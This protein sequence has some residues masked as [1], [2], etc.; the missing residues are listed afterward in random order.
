MRNNNEHFL[1][2]KKTLA[3]YTVIKK[4]RNYLPHKTLKCEHSLYHL[5]RCRTI[6]YLSLQ[7]YTSNQDDSGTE[8]QS[9]FH[10]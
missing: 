1:T 5:G 10:H 9:D 3:H 8:Q 2:I 7:F 6:K 4:E